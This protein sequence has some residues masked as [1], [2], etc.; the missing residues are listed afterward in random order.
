[1]VGI[2]GEPDAV[3]CVAPVL[4]VVVLVVDI[5]WAR[6]PTTVAFP[7]GV[8]MKER[9]KKS[10]SAQAAAMGLIK[11]TVGELGDAVRTAS[12]VGAAADKCATANA[13][14][15]DLAHLMFS[16]SEGKICRCGVK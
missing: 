9:A 15:A 16:I 1:M 8:Q 6:W 12:S 5:F 3:I 11:R 2:I 4:V 13:K 7:L 14:S 10:A